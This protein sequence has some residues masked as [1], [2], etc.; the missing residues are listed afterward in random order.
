MSRPSWL[1]D[2][3]KLSMAQAV[4]DLGLDLLVLPA[5]P[6]LNRPRLQLL[7]LV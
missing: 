1:R 7:R 2:G 3:L 5:S 6:S 4:L